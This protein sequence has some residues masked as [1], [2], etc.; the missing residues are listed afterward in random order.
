M[1][2]DEDLR[3]PKLIGRTGGGGEQSERLRAFARPRRGE[4]GLQVV[5]QPAPVTDLQPR[6]DNVTERKLDVGICLERIAKIADSIVMTAGQHQQ[7]TPIVECDTAIV[8]RRAVRRHREGF[9]IRSQRFIESS[10]LQKSNTEP[11]PGFHDI[12]INRESLVERR[13][14]FV[15][16]SEPGESISASTCAGSRRMTLSRWCL[17]LSSAFF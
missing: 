5:A 16:L 10:K 12:G 2:R 15:T 11:D 7:N 4:K 8:G 3:A 17:A 13:Q 14:S 9:V 1:V 6:A